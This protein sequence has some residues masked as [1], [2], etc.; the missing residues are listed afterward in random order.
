MSRIAIGTAITLLL[1]LFA[2]QVPMTVAEDKPS[3]EGF[4]P[5]F[6][7]KTLEGWKVR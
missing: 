1:G 4:T 7:G 5:I 3:D 6:D 2:M